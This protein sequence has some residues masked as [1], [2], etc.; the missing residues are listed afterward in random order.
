MDMDLEARLRA[1]AAVARR[2]S[3]S[4]AAVELGI[5]QPAVSKH[6]AD[7]ETTLG[8]KLLV[9]EPRG[10]RLTEAGE[11]LASH[12]TRAEALLARA[13]AGVALL[14]DAH[15]G[16][17]TIAAS[18]T[19]GVYLLPKAI[20]PFSAAR[21]GVELDVRLGTSAVAVELVRAH[22]AEVAVVGGGVA[23]ADLSVEPLVEDEVVLVGPPPMGGVVSARDLDN[24]AWISR[25][26]GSGTRVA[27]EAAMDRLGLRPA[28][29]LSLPDW[30]MIK[31]AVA[32]GAGVAAISRF[33]IEDELVSGRLNLLELRG[34]HVVRP[35]SIV[36]SR[37][38]P[39]TPLADHFVA[40][41]RTVLG[42][43][44][45]TVERLAPR[46]RTWSARTDGRAS[47]A[48]VQAALADRPAERGAGAAVVID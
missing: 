3:F 12:V 44:R 22:V 20:G 48:E 7:L 46:S 24:V 47:M 30:E 28:R 11:L 4:R 42:A 16:R 37:D 40:T 19:P 1:F 27:M 17:L 8:T 10:A 21:P 41:V 31:E 15:A 39:L 43:H 36:Y 9:R 33:A 2:G 14:A 38:V 13:A 5:S 32:S 29:R 35:L 45:D 18:G 34:W 6:V 23:T 25:E 26:E